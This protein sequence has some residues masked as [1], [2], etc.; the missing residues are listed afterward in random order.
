MTHAA[1]TTFPRRGEIRSFQDASEVRFGVVISDDVRNEKAN[2]VLLVPLKSTAQSAQSESLPTSGQPLIPSVL[3]GLSGDCR[4]NCADITRVEKS[5]LLD[6]PV[7]TLPEV[8]LMQIVRA[9]RA[10]IGDTLVHPVH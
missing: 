1:Q 2:D 8:H 3:S 5:D 6:G 9:I 4:A 7:G 10:A